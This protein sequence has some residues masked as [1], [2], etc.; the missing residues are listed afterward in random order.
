MM[1]PS[2]YIFSSHNS[3]SPPPPRPLTLGITFTCCS[4]SQL[5]RD[6]ISSP[7]LLRQ[8]VGNGVGHLRYHT[9]TMTSTWS[10]SETNV[11][12][13]SGAQRGSPPPVHRDWDCATRVLLRDFSPV[14]ALAAM[15]GLVQQALWRASMSQVMGEH[16]QL[17]GLESYP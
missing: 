2:N 7:Q 16:G 13:T 5:K 11:K 15:E 1:W 3:S 14:P 8:T 6:P 9:S 4:T 17:R 12:T 10:H